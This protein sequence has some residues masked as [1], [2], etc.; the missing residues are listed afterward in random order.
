MS[1]KCKIANIHLM[2]AMTWAVENL[3]YLRRTAIHR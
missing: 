2:D 1:E 3:D